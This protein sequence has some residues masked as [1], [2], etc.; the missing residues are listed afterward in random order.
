[1]DY[2]LFTDH[3]GMEGWVSLVGLPTEDI[4]PRSGHMSAVD[5]A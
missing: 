4:D 3:E 1:M 5:Q 2:Y